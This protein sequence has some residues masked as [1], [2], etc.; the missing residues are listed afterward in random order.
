MY[1]KFFAVLFSCV[2]AL[3]FTHDAAI[4]R[5]KIYEEGEQVKLFISID[6][7]DLSSDLGVAT[8]KIEMAQ[9]IEYL[10]HNFSIYTNDQKVDFSIEKI[11]LKGDHLH[12]NGTFN[13]MTLAF[14]S[15]IVNNTCLINVEDHSNIIQLDIKDKNYDFRMHKGRS[16]ISIEY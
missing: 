13:K 2:F 4:A 3:S 9:V 16:T 1:M 11:D 7:N 8:S 15:L 14:E 5:F 10:N 6:A 12:L